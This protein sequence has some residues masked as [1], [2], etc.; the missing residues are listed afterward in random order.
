[1][2]YQDQ[3]L[4]LCQGN[5]NGYASHF[6]KGFEKDCCDGVCDA[7]NDCSNYD[8]SVLHKFSVSEDKIK[9][10]FC[11]Y[12]SYYFTY[13]ILHS[14]IKDCISSLCKPLYHIYNLIIRDC[15]FCACWKIAKVFVFF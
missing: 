14:L 13:L 3:E 5:V 10:K 2:L 7:F 1:M 9:I 6:K 11:L 8:T 4:L 12:L 15:K